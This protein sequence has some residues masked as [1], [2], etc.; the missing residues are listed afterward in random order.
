MN[1]EREVLRRLM[2]RLS[3]PGLLIS[4]ETLLRNDGVL[5]SSEYASDAVARFAF[6]PLWLLDAVPEHFDFRSIAANGRVLLEFIAKRRIRL[7]HPEAPPCF[8]EIECGQ[9]F[10]VDRLYLNTKQK[11]LGSRHVSTRSSW[12]TGWLHP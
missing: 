10:H 11:F 4:L 7:D 8:R 3:F 2:H 5:S 6:G 12:R 1:Y 9:P